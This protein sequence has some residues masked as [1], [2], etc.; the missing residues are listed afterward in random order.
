[1][2]VTERHLNIVQLIFEGPLCALLLHFCPS[3]LSYSFLFPRHR[4]GSKCTKGAFGIPGVAAPLAFS[5]R[6]KRDMLCWER[7]VPSLVRVPPVERPPESGYPL[8]Q[9][10][11]STETEIASQK[12]WGP[13]VVCPSCL[14]RACWCICYLPPPL[15]TLSNP[16]S[17][18]W[19]I[20]AKLSRYCES[21][22][23]LVQHLLVS[24]VLF[25]EIQLFFSSFTWN[26]Q[27]YRIRSSIT[28]RI[29]G[30]HVGA[31]NDSTCENRQ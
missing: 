23:P 13:S 7:G 27:S 12:D 26:A 31:I 11:A 6:R 28:N 16:S 4:S 2:K 24:V 29:M 10:L 18:D 30:K 14:S 17:P 19:K 9:C 5:I 15:P 25:M 21:L 20:P 1:M 8:C 22:S 3:S